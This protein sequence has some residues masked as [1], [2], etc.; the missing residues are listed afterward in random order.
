MC[1]AVEKV[2]QLH[3]PN[4]R[5]E[6]DSLLVIK[7]LEVKPSAWF[8]GGFKVLGSFGSNLWTTSIVVFLIFTERVNVLLIALPILVS[9]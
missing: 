8:L 4:F 2:K 5:I 3:I 1:I 7:F 6:C 9:L